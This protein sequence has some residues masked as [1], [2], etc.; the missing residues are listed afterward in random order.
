MDSEDLIKMGFGTDPG[1]EVACWVKRGSERIG[2]FDNG[3]EAELVGE[4][5]A[6][7]LSH[8]EPV[9]GFTDATEFDVVVVVDK[10]GEEFPTNII[11]GEG[12]RGDYGFSTR[13]GDKMGKEL[14]ESVVKQLDEGLAAI[15]DQEGDTSVRDYIIDPIYE[16]VRK[17][18]DS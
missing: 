3:W 13:R 1:P 17:H 4:L 11:T 10:D 12:I 9:E 14:V 18:T 5:V 16:V 6:F 8:S 7:R 2:P 15:A